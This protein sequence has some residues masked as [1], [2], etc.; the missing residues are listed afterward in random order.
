MVKWQ[1]EA[2][3]KAH[4]L[5]LAINLLTKGSSELSA[6]AENNPAL[7]SD[8]LEELARWRMQSIKESELFDLVIETLERDRCPAIN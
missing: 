3:D 2:L 5:T 7:V 1:K 8:W 4:A 6:I